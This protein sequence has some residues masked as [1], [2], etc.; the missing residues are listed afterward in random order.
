MSTPVRVRFAPSP[1]GL[2]HIGNARAAVLNW[3]FASH[4]GGE[5]ILRFDDT[6]RE[7]STLEF[8]EKIQED[9]TWLGIHP[10]R[11]YRQ[12]DRLS[13]YESAAARLK[14]SG[15]LYPCYETGEEL[16]LKRKNQIARGRPPLY[17]RASLH[18]TEEQKK[19][20]EK[21]GRTPH[22]RF[23]IETHQTIEWEDEIRGHVSFEGA[24]LSDPVLIREDGTPLYTFASVVDDLDL[25]ITHII[26][27]ED[28]VVNTAVQIQLIEAL[29]GKAKAFSFAHFTLLTDRE[30]QGFSKRLGS[31][32][33]DS[34]ARQGIEPL[35]VI[36]FLAKVG[37]SD[38]I[39]PHPHLEEIMASFDMKKFARSSPK[40]DLADLEILNKKLLHKMSYKDILP[41]LKDLKLEG[42]DEALWQAVQ[43]NIDQLPQLRVWE[44]VCYR[45]LDPVLQ[46]VIQAPEVLQAALHHLPSEGWTEA[47][48]NPWISAIKADTGATG[49]A[50]FLP[51][52]LA[53]TGH[54]HGPE[55]K[56]LIPLIGLDRCGARLRGERA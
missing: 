50:L 22:W 24:T 13:L 37:T 32:S 51:L 15:R 2:L 43:G 36:N 21:E 53:L 9:L 6:D 25:A 46:S 47:S 56:G 35:T 18:L 27:G 7:R 54:D 10:A 31:L 4:E 12:S 55:L 14:A 8:A 23:K 29:G 1:T 20:Y 40:F 16:S 11:V 28:H 30:G 41:R 17:D 44:E 3:L 49:R 34:F 52:R 33:L 5:F 26:R 38:A 45:P 48:W 39:D 42:V 19:T